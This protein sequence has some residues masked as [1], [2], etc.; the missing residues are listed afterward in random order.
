[1]K[2]WSVFLLLSAVS[3]ALQGASPDARGFIRDWLIG[4]AYPSY[5]VDGADRGFRDD[6]LAEKGG[7]ANLRPYE[8]MRDT[9]LFKADKSKLIAGIGSTNEWGFKEDKTF[10]VVWKT[11]TQ[12]GESP[13]VTLDGRF[14]PIDDHMIVY[15]ACRIESP[16]ARKIRLRIGSD[17]DFKAWLNG[18]LVGSA[19]SSQGVVLDNFLHDAELR[20]GLNVLVLKVVDRTHGSGFCLAVSDRE[21]RPMTDLVIRTDDPAREAE[22]RDNLA[23]TPDAFDNGAYALFSFAE[24]ISLA[25]K[26]T[27][28]VT[29]GSEKRDSCDALLTVNFP[30][31][32]A[33][34][35]RRRIEFTGRPVVWSEPVELPPGSCRAVLALTRTGDAT[36]FSILEKTFEIH[37][38]AAVSKRN[39]ELQKQRAGWLA[40]LKAEEKRKQELIRTGSALEQRHAAHYKMQEEAYATLR[41]KN[42]GG[43]EAQSIDE[44]L[45]PAPGAL[46]RRILLN[47]DRWQISEGFS[48]DAKNNGRT[49]PPEEM[50]KPGILPRTHFNRYF[51]TWYY[52]V[53]NA[54]PKDPYGKVVSR[55]GWESFTFDETLTRQKF[56]ARLDIDLG[57]DAGERSWEFVCET[58]NGLLKVYLNGEYCGR[59]EGNIGIVRIPLKGV[60]PGANRLELY[61]SDPVTEFKL[62]KTPQFQERFGITG[63]LLLESA[64]AGVHLR[65]AAVKTR[66]RN[67]TIETENELVN[68]TAAPAE[69][70]L[71]NSCVLDGRVRFRLPE[72]KGTVPPGGTLTLRSSGI[73]NDP[74]LWGIGGPYGN[75][76]LYD[77]V[78]DLYVGGKLA[79]R[80][81]RPFGFREFWIAGSD[82]FLNGRH[83]ILQGDVGTRGLDNRKHCD[84]LFPLL[85]ADGINTIRN[86]DG[87]FQSPEF[88]RSC[89]R[90]GMLAYANMYPVLH[91][92][93]RDTPE[94]FIPYDEFTASPRHAYNLRNYRRWFRMVRNHPSVVVLSTDNEIF[95]QAWDTPAKEKFNV[96]NDRL[97][98][99]YG[100]YVKNLDPERV[101]TRNGDVGTWGFAEKYHD[102]PPCDTA[103]YHYPDFNIDSYVRNWQSVFGFRPV[104]YGETLYY[105][106]GAWDNWIGAIPE[107]VGKKAKRVAEVARLYR[108]L[109]V[110]GQIYMGLSHDGFVQFD[111]TGRG[112][113]W[114][115]TAAQHDAGNVPGMNGYPWLR[116]P[117]PSLSGTGLKAEFTSID[118]KK[119][120]M[121]VFNWFDA[122]RP[123]HIRNAVNEAYRAAL[124]PMPPVSAATDAECLVELG[125]GGA[126]RVVLAEAADNPAGQYGVMADGKGTAWL[127]LPR[128]G[129]YRL[130]AGGTTR[131]VDIPGRAAY[132]ARPGF[133]RIM[134]IDWRNHR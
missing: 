99:L 48:R 21:N 96:R 129:R 38:P 44:P 128:P 19:N 134:K 98:A 85:R 49:P 72:M 93:G 84:V 47:G 45:A 1:M 105:S 82:F 15:A 90:L 104:I 2:T 27:L 26:N 117:W 106:Y 101:L 130:S 111:D 125:P 43:P 34:T 12:K 132:A 65:D 32:P 35:F 40:K 22:K 109:D 18:K 36:P 75:P 114:G 133:D 110:P 29:V 17:D 77:L 20:R 50:W 6:P 59:W 102:D 63:D 76:V 58:V 124:R 120:G 61:F 100:Q 30:G 91:E 3:A 5:L 122:S 13:V 73:W 81:V 23:R 86:H 97:G 7:E 53:E 25:G 89:D 52:P 115:I 127:T 116:L 64:A 66:F 83:I 119:S 71:V 95:T 55:R 8:G 24:A 70:R 37:D 123:S 51:R 126:G 14:G 41:R 57:P 113:V 56:R 46:R 11:F 4:G 62:T 60:K 94:T 9:A 31:R 121:T 80:S 33:L 39:A 88:F 74:V 107:Q 131:V 92:N 118:V 108:K 54:N 79:D 67:N 42:R 16:E 112:N 69:V 68:R 28:R 103:N 87:A 78:S 10:P